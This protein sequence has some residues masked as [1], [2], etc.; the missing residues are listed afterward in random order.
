MIT[1]AVVAKALADAGIARPLNPLQHQQG[2]AFPS[3]GG[4]GLTVA[5]RQPT[6]ERDS[7]ALN[8][9]SC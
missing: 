4:L 1:A 5:L 9:R 2:E 6:S 3:W 8:I 7:R